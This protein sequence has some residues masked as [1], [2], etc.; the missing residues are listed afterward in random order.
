MRHFYG[1]TKEEVDAME[2]D[3]L[4]AYI[5]GIDLI[6]ARDDMRMFKLVMAQRNTKEYVADLSKDLM[7]AAYPEPI[8]EVK[9]SDIDKII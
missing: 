5:L 9:L 1:F 6:N 8:R 7:T 3:E 2:A 4:E